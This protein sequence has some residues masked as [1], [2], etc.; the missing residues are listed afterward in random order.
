MAALPFLRHS[1]LASLRLSQMEPIK[2][3]DEVVADP[4]PPEAAPAVTISPPLAAPAGKKKPR[5][6]KKAA[7]A[8]SPKEEAATQP[9]AHDGRRSSGGKGSG[10]AKK[11]KEQYEAAA[12]EGLSAQAVSLSEEGDSHNNSCALIRFLLLHSPGTTA[13]RSKLSARSA[14]ILSVAAD[15]LFGFSTDCWL[16]DPKGFSPDDALDS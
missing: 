15:T 1:R 9:A 16:Y 7:A 11:G 8:E 12:P 4:P 5:N 14:L 10:R 13:S 2:L 6:R 3:F